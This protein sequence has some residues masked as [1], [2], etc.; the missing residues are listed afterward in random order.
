MKDKKI[1]VLTII[2]KL[3][4]GGAQK[5]A[6]YTANNLGDDFESYFI[7]GEKGL[8]DNDKID[9]YKNIKQFFNI[10]ELKR[11]VNL[12]FDTISAF[13]IMTI[14]LKIKPDIIHTHSS[15]AGIIGRFVAYFLGIKGIVHT[16]HGFGFHDSQNKIKKFFFVIIERF[17]AKCANKLIAVSKFNIQKALEKKIGKI[18]QYEIIRC[19]IQLKKY[20]SH[21]KSIVVKELEK[22]PKDS[23]IIGMIACFKPQKSPLDFVEI[24]KKLIDKYNEKNLYFVMIG[25]GELRSKI[26][27]KIKNYDIKKR[28]KLLG[29]RTDIY[30]ILHYFDILVLTS[31]FEGL[32]MALLEGIALGVPI[33]AT[34]VD[35]I[36]E[37]IENEK[38]GFLLKCH[39][40]DG[41]VDK[42]SNLLENKNL[43]EI[44]VENGK[45]ILTDEFDESVV[46]EKTKNLY[47]SIFL[48]K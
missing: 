33:V 35:G 9:K 27:E 15:K 46:I 29:W 45:K 23:I 43:R 25:D 21:D 32:P 18:L 38:N 24:A 42:I 11:N 16:Y 40:I 41:F 28:F 26:E 14:I 6:L 3:E 34:N 36:Q 30:E 47:F 39:D 17:A 10:Q 13:K 19:G 4:L 20:F 1:K 48:K 5:V 12:I 7:S 8:L 22:L 31:I 37:I 44:F 2:T